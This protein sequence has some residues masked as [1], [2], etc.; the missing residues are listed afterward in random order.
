MIIRID[1]AVVKTIKAE[2]K[3]ALPKVGSSHLTEAV[4]GGFGFRNN[5]ALM[6]ALRSGPVYATTYP[7]RFAVRLQELGGPSPCPSPCVPEVMESHAYLFCVALWSIAQAFVPVNH[8]EGLLYAF[9]IE[10]YRLRQAF[11]REE[12]QRELTRDLNFGFEHIKGNQFC[13]TV[14]PHKR[15]DV[16]TVY[17]ADRGMVIGL[18]VE[19]MQYALDGV[20]ERMIKNYKPPAE[21]S[22]VTGPVHSEIQGEFDSDRGWLHDRPEKLDS[23]L[24]VKLYPK[25]ALVTINHESRYW[26]RDRMICRL[27]QASYDRLLAGMPYGAAF[28][29]S[30]AVQAHHAYVCERFGIKLPPGTPWC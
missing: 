17:V 8:A 6:A 23:V 1:Q 15:A 21:E 30:L 29:A 12:G 22:L 11:E 10:A 28:A 20:E 26:S 27:D 3:K 19:L 16:L 9:G 24:N 7:N 25:A 14:V 2:L 5:A 13:C 4:A 18:V